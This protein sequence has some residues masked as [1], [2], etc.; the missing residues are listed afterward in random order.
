MGILSTF[1]FT[2]SSSSSSE[3]PDIYPLKFKEK[4]FVYTDTKAIYSRILIDVI[5]RTQG[6]KEDQ[7]PLMWDS[8]LGDQSQDGLIS[9]LARAMTDKTKIALVYDP[10][11]SLI[12]LADAAELNAA[13]KAI[14]SGQTIK[15]TVFVRFDNYDRTDMIKIYSTLEYCAI[16]ALYK[17]MNLSKAIQMKL[18]ELRSSTGLVDS[19]DVKAQAQSIAAALSAGKDV[20]LDADDSIVNAIPDMKA[21]EA[22]MKFIAEKRAYYLGYP[23]RYIMGD[24]KAGIGDTGNADTKE[25]ER[26]HKNY[27][28]SIIK[29]VVDALF[30]INAEFK[31]ENTTAID[32]SLNVL[33]TMELTSERFIGQENKQKIVNMAFQLP[34]NAK[35]D[36]A[37]PVDP[38]TDPNAPPPKN[39]NVNQPSKEGDKNAKV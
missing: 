27:F 34:E 9:L 32:T 21:T 10:A 12:R 25:I 28:F 16:Y 14:K 29:P 17:S 19:D 22:A 13:E 5:E 15:G 3:L 38:K 36:E 8:C 33:K 26:G 20:M 39:G 1:G 7:L 31:S 37:A 24:A 30:D 35:G 6:L 18:K 2:S 23:L 11:I 4:D